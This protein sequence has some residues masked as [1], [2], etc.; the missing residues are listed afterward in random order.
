MD[1]IRLGTTGMEVS[2]ICLGCLGFGTPGTGKYPWS[3]GLDD[4]AVLIKAAFESG[5]NFFDTANVYSQGASEEILGETIARMGVRDD[6]VLAT[7]VYGRM[8]PGPNGAGL[9]RRAILGEVEA[10][11]RRLRADHIDLYQIHRW[12]A[13]TPIE[14]TLEALNDVVRAGKVTYIGASST[15]AWQLA[16]ALGISDCRGWSRFVSMQ[17]HFNL[18]HRDEEREML[19]LCEAEGVGLTAWSPLARGRLARPPEVA[20]NRS[21]TDTIRGLY[22]NAPAQVIAQLGAVAE[23]RGLLWAEVALAWVH[24]S[25]PTVIPVVGV[26]RAEHITDAVA[27]LE[28]EL[29]TDDLESLDRAYFV[30]DPE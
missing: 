22:S 29:S 25:R 6:I 12:D 8:R 27:S 24:A 26:T 21:E 4:S 11:L 19:P 10:S 1:Y 30:R 16:K 3:L 18:L 13:A 5:I 2:R 23:Q 7:K 20:T 15:A 17:V 14:E 28:V 9:S